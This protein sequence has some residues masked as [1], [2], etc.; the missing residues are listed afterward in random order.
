MYLVFSISFF[1]IAYIYIFRKN[2]FSIT[3]S[4]LEK[5]WEYL[6]PFQCAVGLTSQ[7]VESYTY[8][9][10]YTLDDNVRYWL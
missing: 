2:S 10:N 6:D 7:F 8:L 1:S 5:T 4:D 9:R 3:K